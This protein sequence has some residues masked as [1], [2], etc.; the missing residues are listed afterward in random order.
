MDKYHIDGIRV[1]AVASM[2]YLDYS[3]EDGDWIAKQARR[4]GKFGCDFDLLKDSS[5]SR[6]ISN[7]RGVLDNR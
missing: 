1:D 4:S 3:R 2:L 5:T 6:S 7:I